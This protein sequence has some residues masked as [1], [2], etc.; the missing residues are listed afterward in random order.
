[1]TWTKQRHTCL[2]P[3]LAIAAVFQPIGDEWTCDVCGKVYVVTRVGDVKRLMRRGSLP[4]E[5][6]PEPRRATRAEQWKE[7]AERSEERAFAAEARLREAEHLIEQ[8]REV[9][10]G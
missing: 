6:S 9:L 5:P 8:V 3:M 7:Q 10:N 2:H 4:A 1:M